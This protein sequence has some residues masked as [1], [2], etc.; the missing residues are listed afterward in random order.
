MNKKVPIYAKILK[1]GNITPDTYVSPI[2]TNTI[3]YNEKQDKIMNLQR[4]I[5]KIDLGI[6][7][8][9]KEIK[10]HN[11]SEKFEEAI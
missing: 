1:K 7:N 6:Q 11:D 4:Q 3:R 8:I 9:R 5:I 2:Q 10:E